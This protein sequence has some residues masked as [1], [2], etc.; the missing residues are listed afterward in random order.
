M[1]AFFFIYNAVPSSHYHVQFPRSLQGKKTVP[2]P[3]YFICA[4]E[5]KLRAT[6]ADAAS[7]P[8][9][10]DGGVLCPNL[11]YL[12]AAGRRQVPSLFEEARTR[13]DARNSLRVRR[14][15]ST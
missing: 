4:A 8:D 6:P 7:A 1:R 13:R 5:G 3:T 15:T 12:G 14:R 10:P 11:T 9:G 2:L